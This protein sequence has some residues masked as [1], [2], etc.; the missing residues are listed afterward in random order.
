MTYVGRNDDLIKTSGERVGPFEV[1]STLIEHPAVAE[2]GVIGIPD[3]ER[4][5][6]D[7]IKA[8]IVLRKGYS[9]SI[10]L[11]DEIRAFM[12]TKLSGHMAPRAFEFCDSLPRTQSGKIMRRVLKARQLGL[13]I[14][15]TSTLE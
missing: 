10:G 13:P 8:F 3:P 2:A 5:R 12:K 15:D 7:I 6:G 14:G 1:E 11:E 9:P 4:I